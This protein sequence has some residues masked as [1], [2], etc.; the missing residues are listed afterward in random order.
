MIVQ[1]CWYNVVIIIMIL[2]LHSKQ[3]FTLRVV[4]KLSSNEAP[5]HKYSRILS[6]KENAVFQELT[7]FSLMDL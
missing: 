7:Q 6:L 2:S 1:T 3:M 5:L 4:I